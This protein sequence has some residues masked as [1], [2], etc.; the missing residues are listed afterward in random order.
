MAAAPLKPP[1]S[2]LGMTFPTT[3][4]FISTSTVAEFLSI[5]AGA[6][7]IS[8]GVIFLLCAIVPMVISCICWWRSRVDDRLPEKSEYEKVPEEITAKAP[9]KVPKGKKLTK[10]GKKRVPRIPVTPEE[11]KYREYI[12]A[13]IA[14]HSKPKGLIRDDSDLADVEMW[15]ERKTIIGSSDDHKTTAVVEEDSDPGRDRRKPLDLETSNRLTIQPSVF[16]K[17]FKKMIFKPSLLEIMKSEER[18][19]A[20]SLVQNWFEFCQPDFEIPAEVIAL[21]MANPHICID[22]NVHTWDDTA[23]L[24]EEKQFIH[25]SIVPMPGE[26][27]TGKVIVCQAPMDDTF[28]GKKDTR[29]NFWKMVKDLDSDFIVMA[30]Q[31]LENKKKKCGKYFPEKVDQMITYGDMSVTLTDARE[32]YGGELMVRHFTIYHKSDKEATK[33]VKHFQFLKWKE[34]SIPTGELPLEAFKFVNSEVR[35]Q[36]KPYVCHSSLGTGRACVFVG[37]EYM[38]SMVCNKRR[39]STHFFQIDFRTKRMGALQTGEQLYFVQNMAFE[40]LL[41]EFTFYKYQAELKIEWDRL[42]HFY[43]K[44]EKNRKDLKELEE[45]EKKK[46]KKT[47][48]FTSNGRKKPILTVTAP[49]EEKKDQNMEELKSRMDAVKKTKSQMKLT[50]GSKEKA[51]ATTTKEGNGSKEPSKEASRDVSRDGGTTDAMT[52]NI[53]KFGQLPS[54]IP[55]QDNVENMDLDAEEK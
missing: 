47:I 16:E 27:D 1:P 38:C 34:R 48:P 43:E 3:T 49:K 9:A 52:A 40:L 30:C 44:G 13:F 2:R 5:P 35:R 28:V 45:F 11:K 54:T 41:K 39:A 50:V 21:S 24:V 26:G 29:R 10:K 12:D 7:V 6:V 15:V 20:K 31:H 19:P 22:H 53:Q 4:E 8:V 14:R 25:A 23:Y 55:K 36:T 18:D 17:L 33:N 42:A 51:T 37:V 32:M 46:F